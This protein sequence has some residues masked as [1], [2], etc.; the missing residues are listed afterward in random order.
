M[1]QTNQ[2]ELRKVC[3]TRKCR[4]K[5][6]VILTEGKYCTACGSRLQTLPDADTRQASWIEPSAEQSKPNGSAITVAGTPEPPK[7]VKRKHNTIW[8]EDKKG[9]VCWCGAGPFMTNKSATDHD[10]LPWE[11][12]PADSIAVA[13]GTAIVGSCPAAAAKA[14]SDNWGVEPDI[15]GCPIIELKKPRIEIPYE[16]YKK[17]CHLARIIP[18]EWLAYLIGEPLPISETAPN[19]GWKITGMWYPKQKVTTAHVT[20]D[21][22]DLR[23][24]KPGTI[25][26]IHS[27]NTMSSFFS[28]EDEKHFNHQVHLVCNARREF[29]SSIRVTLDCQRTSRM[30]G[31]LVLVNVDE[32]EELSWEEE[33]NKIME[34]ETF[35]GGGANAGKGGGNSAGFGGIRPTTA[36]P[37]PIT[38][39]YRY[40]HGQHSYD[41]KHDDKHDSRGRHDAW[42]QQS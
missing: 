30:K 42:G 13:G 38:P 34:V 27:H 2:P 35:G 17:W 33:L 7:T 8:D 29:D 18:T 40:S 15:K 9:W 10:A 3:D 36:P 28:T 24:L 39:G 31:Q 37:T 6:V 11:D 41:S 25:G 26:D 4:R 32:S 5:N 1:V 14:K 23:N 22:N 16:F 21:E 20:V 12:V 19:G